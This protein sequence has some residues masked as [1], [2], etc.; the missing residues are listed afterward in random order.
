MT[1]GPT[2]AT[3]KLKKIAE[4]KTPETEQNASG[5]QGALP[6]DPTSFSGAVP[7]TFPFHGVE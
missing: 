3:S 6:Q 7:A 2:A 5:R 4:K 1:P